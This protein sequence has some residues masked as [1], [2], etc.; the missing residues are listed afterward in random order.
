LQKIKV[1]SFGVGVIGSML[2]KTI[3]EQKKDWLEIVGAVDVDANKIGKDLGKLAGSSEC[4][5]IVTPD[6]PKTIS[7]SK[8][9]LVLHTTSSYLEK[10][11]PELKLLAECGV[12]VISSCEE[13]SYPYPTNAHISDELDLVAK[14]NQV[15]LLGTGINPG[16]LMDVLPIL[17][18]TPCITINKI[19]VERQ[20]N[21]ANRRIPFQKKIGAGLSPKDFKNAVANKSISSH[22]GLFQSISMLADSLGWKLDKVGI[23]LPEPVIL[24]EEARS[25]WIKVGKGMAAGSRQR[26]YG[27]VR[28]KRIIDYVFSAYIGA[29]EEFDQVDVDGVPKVCFKSNPCVNGDSGTIALLINMIPK[30]LLAPPGLLTM[31]DLPLPSAANIRIP[32]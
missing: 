31:K 7:E 1:L 8:P 4:G 3:L 29:K 5:V 32:D 18:T 6:A 24:S 12:D 28:G 23:E 15:S 2:A 10:T 14:K 20:M 17:L 16:F 27:I 30:I 19:H 11:F 22:V 21:A 9:D 25:D 13:L 26:A